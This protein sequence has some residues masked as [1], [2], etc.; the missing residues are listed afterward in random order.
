[1]S[2]KVQATSG[3]A[4][5]GTLATDHGSVQT[6]AF[7]PVATQATVKG[8]EPRTLTE[9][10][11]RMAIMNTYHLWLRPGP[12]LIAELGGL[13]SFS[14][15][16]HVI[17]TDSGGFQAFSLAQRTRT[18]DAGFEFSSHLDGKRC[19]L[20]PEEAMR[21]QGL[22][23]SD[24][25]MQLDICAP[26]NSSPEELVQAVEQT[27]RWAK[28]CLASRRVGQAVFGIVQ[29]GSN[30]A[31]RLRHAEEL[32]SL[33]FE[34]LAL[35]GFSVGE[36]PELMHQT[37]REVVFRMDA[38]RPRYLMGVGTQQDLIRAIGAGVDMFDCVLPTRNARN[39]QAFLT[40]GKLVIRNQKFRDDPRVLEP[41]CSC[42]TCELG[43]S[44][45]FIRHAYMAGEM[46]ALRLI[47]VH[48]LHLYQ[49]LVAEA[50]LSILQ[51]EFEPWAAR[52]LERLNI[53]P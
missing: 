29:G 24:I 1:M 4:R 50:R 18:S 8:L 30:V 7:M 15:F 25:A 34:G 36:P 26:A 53:E 10:G 16:P 43:F 52:R 45:A 2:F 20:S 11:A 47:T 42:P 28:R 27:T 23:G 12:E 32:A 41:G 6:P 22:L 33:P 51:G 44:R 21:V 37:L 14:R 35:G 3:K 39:G 17:V 31:L 48:N 9:M 5:A 38:A 13:H 46:T 49:S 19:F 40:N